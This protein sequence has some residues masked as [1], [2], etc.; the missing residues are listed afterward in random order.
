MM[1]SIS[2]T[3]IQMGPC[4]PVC[5]SVS[6]HVPWPPSLDQGKKTSKWDVPSHPRVLPL[7]LRETAL[8]NPLTAAAAQTRVSVPPD[9]T[10]ASEFNIT[11]DDMA[12]VIK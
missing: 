9:S 8:P 10:I 4:R 3:L 2:L 1:K 7:P 11:N 12:I 5:P 6:E